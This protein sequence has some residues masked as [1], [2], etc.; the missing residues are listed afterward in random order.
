ME[1]KEGH[2][3]LKQEV[4]LLYQMVINLNLKS[5]GWCE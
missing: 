3:N 5:W 4:L 1:D 2:I